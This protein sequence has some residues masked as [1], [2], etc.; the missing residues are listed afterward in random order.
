MSASRLDIMEERF[1]RYCR[2]DTQSNA[3]SPATPSTACQ[4]DLSR[5]LVDELKGLGIDD[6]ELTDYGVVFGTLKGNVA[7][8]EAPT[9]AFVAHVDTAP[10]FF[11][12]GVKPLVHRNWD[13]RA[14]VLPD[15][16]EVVI[17]PVMQPYLRSKQGETIVTASGTTLLGADDKAGIAIIM[18]LIDHL[19][20]HPE[21]PRGDVRICFTPD[22]EIGRGVSDAMVRDLKAD[23]AYTL[24]G[25]N[26]GDLV[27]ETFSA[28][29]AVVNIKGIS[30]HTCCAK[31]RLVNALYLASE[32]IALLPKDHLSPEST[33]G[34]E[35][36]I[37]VD[38]IE[39]NAAELNMMINLRDF[40]LEGLEKQ[41]ELLRTLCEQVNRTEPRA[42]ITCTVT[43]QYR[44]MRYW[45][46]DDPRPVDIAKRAYADEGF[47]PNMLA[48]RGGTD[49]SIM[50]EKGIPTP[51][52]FCG[53]QAPHGPM[54]WVSLQDM[55]KALSICAR[56]VRYWAQEARA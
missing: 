56:V 15:D 5:M 6:A 1:V 23:F 21:I 31:G 28:D 52:I 35:G 27:A 41:A 10:S 12:E 34:R 40:E 38:S 19:K 39:G 2:V 33:E 7:D 25:E 20:A 22:E 36:F 55:D 54:E 47:P 32:I 48:F 4:L 18:G 3:D 49:G 26:P 46:K 53:M 44:N 11:A 37:F 45:L 17:D 29:K 14:I 42:R 8:N 9:I 30:I 50:T 51:N 43:P 16:P 24:D 13:G